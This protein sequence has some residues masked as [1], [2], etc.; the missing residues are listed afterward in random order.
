MGARTFPG[1]ILLCFA[2]RDVWASEAAADG[3]FVREKRYR[4]FKAWVLEALFRAEPPAPVV[5][6]MK[7]LVHPN[8]P[9]G[10][11]KE[12]LKHYLDVRQNDRDYRAVASGDVGN[13]DCDYRVRNLMEALIGEKQQ[14]QKGGSTMNVWICPFFTSRMPELSRSSRKEIAHNT[15]RC[16]RVEQILFLMGVSKLS[17]VFSNRRSRK[18]RRVSGGVESEESYLESV[19]TF[20]GGVSQKLG[21]AIQRMV[22][23]W[24][25]IA[26]HFGFESLDELLWPYTRIVGPPFEFELV[27]S[28][29]EGFV[30]KSERRAINPNVALTV[31]REETSAIAFDRSASLDQSI[32]TLVADFF[33]DFNSVILADDLY[34]ETA[35][36]HLKEYDAA[37]SELPPRLTRLDSALVA[38]L[39]REMSQ[40]FVQRNVK[41]PSSSAKGIEDSQDDE[42]ETG[43]VVSSTDGMDGGN[44]GNTGPEDEQTIGT[45]LSTIKKEMEKSFRML[46]CSFEDMGE[47]HEHLYPRE[48]LMESAQ[49]V[50]TDPPFNIRRENGYRN[51]VYDSLSVKEMDAVVEVF[52]EVLKPGG[53][54]LLFCTGQQ[55]PLW[56]QKFNSYRR[57]NFVADKTA[58][59]MAWHPAANKSFPGRW[60]TT[61]QNCVEQAVHVKKRGL[62][63]EQEAEVVNYSNFNYVQSDY[64]GHKNVI[65]NVRGLEAGEQ[66]RIKDEDAEKVVSLR[67]EQKPVSLLKELISRFSQPGDL[68]VDLFGGTFS[69]AVACFSLRQHRRFL[70]CELDKRCFDHAFNHVCV[71]FAQAVCDEGGNLEVPDEVKEA[72]KAVKAIKK[73]RRPDGNWEAPIGMPQYQAVQEQLVSFVSN[74][75]GDR[76]LY[77]RFKHR[78]VHEWPDEMQAKL[79]ETGEL[80]LRAIDA[81]ANGV[82]VQKSKIKCAFAGLGVFAIRSFGPGDVIGPFYGT[83]VYHNLLNR[84]DS[85]KTYGRGI[86]GVTV[87]RFKRFA[88]QVRV[89]GK[90]FRKIRD[91]MDGQKAVSIVPA[92]FCAMGYANDYRYHPEDEE[93]QIVEGRRKANA[94]F[95]GD[96]IRHPEQLMSPF[97]QVVTA[98]DFINPGDEIYV[99]YGNTF[100]VFVGNCKKNPTM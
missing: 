46:C 40:E 6:L 22:Y 69:T 33:R 18:K 4:E 36:A 59:V 52:D 1:Y 42:Q 12:S 15:K 9:F 32:R 14:T 30:P 82:V 80:T 23:G 17:A 56:V 7:M 76:S 65:N 71:Q 91:L 88:I 2:C 57:K 34:G 8:D 39:E 90:H 21:H 64:P 54:G 94:V 49:L 41:Q 26:T 13:H 85:R 86:L 68:V 11:S 67:N 16:S 29:D 89:E 74:V 84:G 24:N 51:S 43:G 95:T 3:V 63:T 100:E 77:I 55:F 66:V 47:A 98:T 20:T 79:Q 62:T 44:D 92:R 72:A 28:R 48:T 35:W 97:S 60:S 10:Y 5:E 19:R 37:D 25:K 87:D 45:Y 50:L 83:L 93:S 53:H 99:D 73:K 61:L 96:I 78:G 31:V 27:S 75:A 81:L 70:G 58:L 38:V